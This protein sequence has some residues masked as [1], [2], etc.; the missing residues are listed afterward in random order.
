[1]KTKWTW[2]LA[3]VSVGTVFNPARA[4]IDNVPDGNRFLFVVETS[5]ASSRLEH[6]GRQAA[7][8]LIY[9]GIYGQMRSGDTF[10]LWTFHETVFAGVYAVQTWTPESNLELATRA[11]QFLR[12]QHYDR[13]ARLSI[14][15]KH[16]VGMIRTVNDV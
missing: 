9:S 2:L 5:L 1:M 16:A 11:G 13:T 15:L 10:G 8:D 12:S 7:F 14:A 4:A 3:L 6:G